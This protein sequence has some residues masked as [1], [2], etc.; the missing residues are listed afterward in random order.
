[1]KD[2]TLNKDKSLVNLANSILKHFGCKTYHNSISEIDK[3]IEESGKE[4]ICLFL[5]D[6]FGKSILE[7]YKD[8]APFMYSHRYL[9]IESVFPPTTVAST[10]S[11]TTGKYPIE[12]GY[13]GWTQYF[14]SLDKFVDVFPSTEKDESSLDNSTKS[15]GINI[16][17]T[18]LKPRYIFDDINQKYGKKVSKSIMS[19]HYKKEG[20]SIE[21]VNNLWAKE[22]DKSISENLY[23]YAYNVYPDSL[24]HEFGVNDNNVRNVIIWINNIVETLVK[25]HPDTLFLCVSDHGMINVKQFNIEDIP[26]FIETLNRPVIAIE[27]RFASFFIKDKDKFLDIYKSNPLLNEHFL[28]LSKEEILNKHYFGYSDNINPISLETIGDYTLISLDEYSLVDKFT[29]QHPFIGAHAGLS[30]EEKEI[31]LQAYNVK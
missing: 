15:L 6:A 28:L 4:K 23:T 21:Q 10:T 13:L 22:V 2:I 5:F 26:G 19:F 25:K 31:Y 30:K 17:K 3:L 12:T 24:M 7:N 29:C 1:M 27:G 9:E 16:E 11:I 8:D 20:L 14:K 18:I